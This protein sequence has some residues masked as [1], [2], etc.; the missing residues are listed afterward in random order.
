MRW[1]DASRTSPP[2]PA[3]APPS[4]GCSTSAMAPECRFTRCKICTPA[5]QLHS[6]KLPGSK[7]G[8]PEHIRPAFILVPTFLRRAW[9]RPRRVSGV[10]YIIKGGRIEMADLVPRAHAPRSVRIDV[11]HVDAGVQDGAFP[12]HGE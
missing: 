8:G 11:E 2:V 5:G 7:R 12:F 3:R 6:Q 10:H 1:P 9:L 4:R